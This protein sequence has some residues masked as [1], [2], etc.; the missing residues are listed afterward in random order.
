MLPS[1]DNIAN[2]LA[3][4]P[5]A[6]EGK[7]FVFLEVSPLAAT[8]CLESKSVL[9]STLKGASTMEEAVTQYYENPDKYSQPP[10]PPPAPHPAP[11]DSKPVKDTKASPKQVDAPPTYFPPQNTMSAQRHRPHTNVVINAGIVRARDEVSLCLFTCGHEL[12]YPCLIARDAE[13]APKRAALV[14]Y[15]QQRY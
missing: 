7:A 11:V 14:W 5:E 13:F 6:D 1:E 2:F 12:I 9:M 10:A 8:R 4:A 3:F 15:I